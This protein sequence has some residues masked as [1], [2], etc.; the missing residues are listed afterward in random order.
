MRLL[1]VYKCFSW[2]DTAVRV[3]PV[4]LQYRYS[5]RNEAVAII[6][7][8]KEPSDAEHD[9]IIADFGSMTH[10]ASM[11]RTEFSEQSPPITLTLGTTTWERL[12]EVLPLERMHFR[13]SLHTSMEVSGRR[14]LNRQVY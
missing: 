9:P 14:M 8:S 2:R 11:I 4:S 10:D 7:V 6:L 13:S 5:Q 3:A 1:T 12:R